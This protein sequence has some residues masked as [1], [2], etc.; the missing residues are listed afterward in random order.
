M[1][2]SRKDHDG[3]KS[4]AAWKS[5]LE[6]EKDVGW[7][8]FMEENITGVADTT[9]AFAVI[10]RWQAKVCASRS[11]QKMSDCPQTVVVWSFDSPSSVRRARNH[12]VSLVASAAATYSASMVDATTVSCQLE[13]HVRGDPKKKET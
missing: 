3:W 8:V 4:L 6:G 10:N 11:L 9:W 13:H 1:K 2:A 12:K 5:E 7:R